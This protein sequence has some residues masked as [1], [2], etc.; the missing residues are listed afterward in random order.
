MHIDPDFS[1]LLG[2]LYQG[3]LEEQ[4]WQ[5][6]LASVREV[7][8]A[9]LV[10]L[11][12]RPPSKEDQVVMLDTNQ[13]RRFAPPCGRFAVAAREGGLTHDGKSLLTAHLAATAKRKVRAG[14][15][16][17]DGRSQ[18]VVV[19]ADTRKIDATVAGILAY[20]AAMTMPAAEILTDPFLIV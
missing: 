8:G 4:P 1:A 20:E 15:D 13:S 12:L 19:K 14:D 17:D 5:S 11:L 9:N 10:T 2:D 16:D 3:P 6:F 18:F 7:L